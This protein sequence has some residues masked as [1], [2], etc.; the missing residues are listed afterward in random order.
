MTGSAEPRHPP[1][2][3]PPREADVDPGR[4]RASRRRSRPS[5]RVVSNTR[6]LLK[7]IIRLASLGGGDGSR[8]LALGRLRIRES[9]RPCRPIRSGTLPLK[10]SRSRQLARGSAAAGETCLTRSREREPLPGSLRGEVRNSSESGGCSGRRTSDAN[11]PHA[12]MPDAIDRSGSIRSND[13]CSRVVLG[14]R[15]VE[16]LNDSS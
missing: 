6:S 5:S 10:G 8:M 7:R 2:Q 12:R 11:A 1:V 3:L 14:P 4:D 13:Q 9:G 16:G 15:A